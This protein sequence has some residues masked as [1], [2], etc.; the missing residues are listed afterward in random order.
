MSAGFPSRASL[1]SASS[2]EREGESVATPVP[3]MTNEPTPLD[4]ALKRGL[5]IATPLASA[6]GLAAE[7]SEYTIG[8]DERL[9]ELFSLSYEQN[10]PTWYASALLLSCATLLAARRATRRAPRRRTAAGGGA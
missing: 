9:V 1:P 10:V 3:R 4:L 2:R 8:A 7:L 6:A 5:W